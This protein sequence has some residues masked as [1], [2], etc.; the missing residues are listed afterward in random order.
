MQRGNHRRGEHNGGHGYS[1]GSD[2]YQARHTRFGSDDGS[3]MAYNT[4]QQGGYHRHYLPPSLPPPVATHGPGYTHHP[5]EYRHEPQWHQRQDYHRPQG[6]GGYEDRDE[7][8]R[9]GYHQHDGGGHRG[10]SPTPTSRKRSANVHIDW[11][12][13]GP[14][15]SGNVA[16]KRAREWESESSPSAATV[17]QTRDNRS[18]RASDRFRG[19]VGR[20]KDNTIEGD[21]GRVAAKKKSNVRLLNRELSRLRRLVPPALRHPKLLVLDLNGF[22]VY[23]RRIEATP[24]DRHKPQPTRP[25]DKQEGGFRV[26]VRPH[27]KTFLAYLLKHFHV[28]VW[29]SAQLRNVMPLLQLVLGSASAA[30]EMLVFIWS[31]HECTVGQGG[32][33]N[34]SR[35]PLFHKEINRIFQ[36]R[37]FRGMY[38]PFPTITWEAI[39]VH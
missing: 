21:L 10:P 36:E 18:T 12:G 23:R 32:H 19:S 27:A 39:F 4:H 11:G 34:D 29:S 26:W 33:P 16:P 8:Q 14:D 30:D 20:H 6:G 35:R 37:S 5:L 28:A 13:R 15:G 17:D 22:L 25:H 9:H 31:Q 38:Q 7:S 2:G 1:D 3:A 24:S